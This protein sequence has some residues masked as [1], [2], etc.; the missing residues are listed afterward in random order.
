MKIVSDLVLLGALQSLN[1]HKIY[2][3]K[4]SDTLYHLYFNSTC[5]ISSCSYSKNA[6]VK[7]LYKE[8]ILN[9]VTE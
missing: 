1:S 8:N 6:V 3:A 2:E 5:G 7:I 9:S 4:E